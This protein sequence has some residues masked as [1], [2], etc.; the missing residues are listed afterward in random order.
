[1]A[2][3]LLTGTLVHQ[4]IIPAIQ[5]QSYRCTDGDWRGKLWKELAVSLH[6]SRHQPSAGD[7]VDQS[8]MLEWGKRTKS[9]AWTTSTQCLSS[10]LLLEGSEVF[11]NSSAKHKQ[12]RTSHSSHQ[13]PWEHPMCSPAAQ[14]ASPLKR[15]LQEK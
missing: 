5:L 12:T 6:S 2:R 10:I 9:Q 13:H 4:N 8:S 7:T 15:S 14:R 11:C 1:M 3:S